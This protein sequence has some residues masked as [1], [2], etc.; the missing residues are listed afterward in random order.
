MKRD[1]WFRLTGTAALALI[2]A[3][4]LPAQPPPPDQPPPPSQPASPGWRKFGEPRAADQPRDAR[5]PQDVE[6][7]PPPPAAVEDQVP[8][9]PPA[10]TITLPAG[11]FLTIRVNQPLSSNQNLAGD[12]FTATLTQPLVADGYV[13]ARRGQTIAGRV[14]DV[15]KAGRIKGSSRL[16]LEL[17][18][19]SL[20]DG[21]QLPVRTQLIEYHGGTSVGRDATAVG[22]ATGVG[23]AIG[24]AA[25]GGFGAG[26]GA[27][28]GAAASTIGVL[29]T[30]GRAT[31]VFPEAELTFRTMAPLT[32]N[33]ERSQHAFHPVRQGDYEQRTLQR[34][35]AV[36]PV[37]PF[38]PM[39]YGGGWGWPYYWG[40]PGVFFNWGPRYYGRGWR[41][42]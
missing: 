30:R 10:P 11:T 39:W 27:I 32:I 35:A 5:P 1:F 22:T 38:P 26:M 15:V 24:A 21:Q 29:V 20:V 23:A 17:T 36:R 13:I 31:E 25:D 42:W 41:R 6:A 7:P 28:A 9:Q 14:A 12:P 40:G 34:R 18:E 37:Q 8:A 3:M 16:G 2:G 33:T 4:V 19:I